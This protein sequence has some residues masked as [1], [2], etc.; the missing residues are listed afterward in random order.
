MIEIRV[1]HCLHPLGCGRCGKRDTL[2]AAQPGRPRSTRIEF[3]SVND[4]LV[5]NAEAG[6][7]ATA[8]Y[9]FI[10]Q[11]LVHIETLA[12]FGA[13][14]A[15]LLAVFWIFG[16]RGEKIGTRAAGLQPH[17]QKGERKLR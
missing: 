13:A 2:E 7:A 6:I 9:H 1:A 15:Q 17:F 12:A 14:Y 8:F 4:Y 3:F 16:H 11:P 10:H 5:I